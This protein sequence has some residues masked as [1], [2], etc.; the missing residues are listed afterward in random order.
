MRTTSDCLAGKTNLKCL[1]LCEGNIFNPTLQNPHKINILF[2][3]V[4]TSKELKRSGDVW[5]CPNTD[6]VCTR[7]FF[8]Y[9]NTK[10]DASNNAK[11]DTRQS[12]CKKQI[13]HAIEHIGHFMKRKR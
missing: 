10:F 8:V 4:V 11:F 5:V 12:Q 3:S 1:A 13:N 2:C 7:F 9:D 6:H